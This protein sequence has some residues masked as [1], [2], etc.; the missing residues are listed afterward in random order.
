MNL[1]ELVSEQIAHGFLPPAP[2]SIH[3]PC[4]NAFSFLNSCTTC[5]RPTAMDAVERAKRERL[6]P[7]PQSQRRRFFSIILKSSHYPPSTGCPSHDILHL[8]QEDHAG[9]EQPHHVGSFYSI[10]K[11]SP[12]GAEGERI[13]S[14]G[15]TSWMRSLHSSIKW[16]GST[17]A[18]PTPA[19]GHPTQVLVGL[20]P[21]LSGQIGFDIWSNH[22]NPVLR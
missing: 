9:D 11:M 17:T 15:R 7:S 21:P 5:A 14:S 22:R 13:I 2:P 4:T 6:R 20:C 8:V 12:E 19:N 16:Q 3:P 18:H 10:S 1:S